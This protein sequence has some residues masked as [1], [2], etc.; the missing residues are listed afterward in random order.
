MNLR[1][2]MEFWAINRAS[3]PG[4]DLEK[5]ARELDQAAIAK[6]VK[7]AEQSVAEAAIEHSRRTR[8]DLFQTQADLTA[9]KRAR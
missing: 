7:H 5:N 8:E 1:H 3:T 9:E 4:Q 6:K 2:I